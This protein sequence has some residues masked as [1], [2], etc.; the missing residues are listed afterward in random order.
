MPLSARTREFPRRQSTL[1]EFA[2]TLV[3]WWHHAG[4]KD[5][6]W[7]RN[8]TAYRVWVSEVML[9]QTQAST[10]APYFKRFMTRFPS[11]RQLA[12]ASED[13][14]LEYWT[15]LGYYRRACYLHMAAIEIVGKHAGQVPDNVDALVTLPGIGR[16]TAG[17]IV[18]IAF[19]KNATILDGNVRRVVSRFYTVS[20]K[21]GAAKTEKRLWDYAEANTPTT[22]VDVYSQAIMDLGATVCI[23]SKPKCPICPLSGECKAHQRGKE[24]KY[25]SVRQHRPLRLQHARFFV[26]INGQGA[27]LLKKRPT[28]GVWASLWSPP[29]Y[30]R[31]TSVFMLCE[32]IG[33]PA[34][35]IAKTLTGVKFRHAFSHFQLE[36]EPIYIFL[37]ASYPE[38]AQTNDLRWHRPTDRAEFGLSAVAVKLLAEIESKGTL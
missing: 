22:Q 24:N 25:P 15:G 37:H 7:Q 9:Q 30:P 12:K 32:E 14:V 18:A 13:E 8:K 1:T 20:G 3:D 2:Q 6:P 34:S 36:I 31:A 26:V 27:C 11:V 21:R 16:S 5:L 4:R 17:A 33:L 38:I 10:V 35:K 29:Q 28:N 23:R 19:N